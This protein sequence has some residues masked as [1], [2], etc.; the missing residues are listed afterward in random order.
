MRIGKHVGKRVEKPPTP[1]YAYVGKPISVGELLQSRK[2]AEWIVDS[3]GAQ[4]AA[5]ILSADVGTGKTTFLYSLASSISKGE[6]FLKNDEG[7]G[8]L[9]TKI[10]GFRTRCF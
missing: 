4:G 7:V 5:V 10:D 9:E 8:Q 6:P 1:I 3:F 2:K